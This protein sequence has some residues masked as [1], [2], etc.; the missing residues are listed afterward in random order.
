MADALGDYLNSIARYPLLTTEQE[1]QLGRRIAKWRELQQLDR[2]LTIQ[3]QREMRSGLRARQRFM[4]SNLQLVVHV[5]RKYSRRKRQTLEMIDLIQEGN[6]GLARAVELFDYSRG[7]KFST[8]AY[9]WIR[10]SIGRAIIQSDAIIRLPSGAHDLLVKISR[11]A[12]QF[13]QSNGRPATIS[14]LSGLVEKPQHIILAALRQSFRVCSLDK[15]AG[16][17]DDTSAIID[18]IPSQESKDVDDDMQLEVIKEYCELYLDDRTRQL[19]Y[20]RNQ[21]DP[22]P[23]RDLERIHGVSRARLVEMYRRGMSRLKMLAGG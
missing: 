12:E 15:Q 13:A 5:A 2:P 1:I 17:G 7:Y 16:S 19:V 4:Q 10:Q 14:E 21:A 22:V 18:L 9:W 11:A 20:A 3:E 23:W 6:L 8:Y